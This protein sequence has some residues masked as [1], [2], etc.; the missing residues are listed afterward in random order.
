VGTTDVDHDFS[1]DE[2]PSISPTEFVYLMEAVDSQFASLDLGREDVLATFA[3]IRPVIG[4][5]KADPSKE[6]RDHVL[7]EEN[8]LLTVT[9]GK[10]TT[11]RLIALDALKAARAHLPTIRKIDKKQPAL[12]RVDTGVC[13]VATEPMRLSWSE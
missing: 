4:T 9:G 5:G 7:W 11:F 13:S 2:E 10:L 12:D 6:S 3:G 1:L 8:G